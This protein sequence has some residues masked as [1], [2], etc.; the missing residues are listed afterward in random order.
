MAI[1]TT[2]SAGIAAEV[3]QHYNKN[4]LY[5]ARP[6]LVHTL[7][8]QKGVI[9]G[10]MGKTVNW[11]RFTK[12]SAATTALSEGVTPNETSMVQV[13]ISATVAQYGS[14]F[15]F[16]DVVTV[17]SIDPILDSATELLGQNAGETLD[18]IAQ[19]AFNAG[20]NVRYASLSTARTSRSAVTST[21]VFTDT[22][23]RRIRRQMA[24][25]NVPM[26]NVGGT[27]CYVAVIHPNVVFDLQGTS[28]YVAIGQYSDPDNI[29]R[30]K[31][32]DLYSIKFFESSNA[33]VFTGSG[34]SGIDVYSTLIMGRDATGQVDIESLGLQ[35][36]YKGSASGG[37]S[38][39]LNQRQTSGWKASYAAVILNDTFLLRFESAATA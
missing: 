8:S 28:N 6:A 12:M 26:V 36:I 34:A 25:N 18:T 32:I 9:P 38:D 27:S 15:L 35:F 22:E 14:Y 5:F 13:N 1:T 29:Y 20:N 39:P 30:G 24:A 17:T 19:T 33:K 3:R 23:A 31:V 37:T 16:S 2:G 21:D 11:R 7:Y 10:G 4:L